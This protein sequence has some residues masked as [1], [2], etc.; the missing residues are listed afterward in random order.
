MST[1]ILLTAGEAEAVRGPSG[2]VDHAALAPVALI[3]GRFIL[4]AAV[5]DDPAHAEHH[6]MLATLPTEEEE[7]LEDLFVK[8]DP[9]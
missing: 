7:A 6:A 2:T 3:D 5:L 1:M 4:P 8:D 9:A